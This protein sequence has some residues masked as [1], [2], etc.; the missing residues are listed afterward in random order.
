VKELIIGGQTTKIDPHRPPPTT[1]STICQ[2]ESA[3]CGMISRINPPTTSGVDPTTPRAQRGEAPRAV[4]ACDRKP[5][6]STAA[7]PIS[8]GSAEIQPA[9]C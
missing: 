9:C 8:H 5:V 4:S 6:V 2:A 7:A 3:R 1:T